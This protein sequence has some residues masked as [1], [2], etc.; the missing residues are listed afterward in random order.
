MDTATV[1]ITSVVA[2]W[3]C[4]LYGKT[5]I[6]GGTVGV[7]VFLTYMGAEEGKEREVGDADE[8]VVERIDEGLRVSMAEGTGEGDATPVACSAKAV[9]VF[10]TVEAVETMAAMGQATYFLVVA[11]MQMGCP[12]HV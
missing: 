12:W 10:G 6:V 4:H 3:L 9:F 8:K 11:L 7:F 5:E 1:K 2:L